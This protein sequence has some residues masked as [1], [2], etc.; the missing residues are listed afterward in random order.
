MS[1]NIIIVE[2]EKLA[3]GKLE[4][5]ILKYDPEFSIQA[6]IRSVAEAIAWFENNA[7]LDLAFIDIQLTDGTIFDLVDKVKISCPVIFTTAY[8]AYALRAF[9]L[10][11]IDYLIKPFSQF[12]LGKAIDKL[13]DM[14]ADFADSG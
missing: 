10:K 2:D 3:A 12:K 4:K 14:K 7:M 9:E 13:V 11:S 8:D 1:M 6:K 5:M